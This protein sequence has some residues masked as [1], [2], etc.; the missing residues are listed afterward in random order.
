M[1]VYVEDVPIDKVSLC[2]DCAKHPELKDLVAS[3]LG[4]GI[5]GACGSTGP[6]F[7]PSRF[8]AVRN[9]IR[10][11]IRLNFDEQDY[12]SHWGGTSIDDILLGTE[13]P[14]IRTAKP[15]GL[16]DEFIYR[17][18]EEGGVYPAYDQGICLFAG[19]DNEGVRLLQFSIPQTA[20]RELKDI[21]QRLARENFHAVEAAMEKLVDSIA[22]DIESNIAE[23]TLWYR[24]RIGFSRT[25]THV[26]FDRVT[27]IVTPY[28]GA[29]ISALAP[30]RAS[31]GR[32]NRA[33]VS[34]LYVASEIE[35]ALAEIRPHPGH[36][37]SVAG[38]RPTRSFRVARFDVPIG[39]FCNSDKRLDEYAL[40]HHVDSL[41]SLPVVP[42]ERHLYATTQLLADVLIRRGFDAI[43]YRSSVGTGK[44]LCVFEP[45]LF[46][47]DETAA[48][49]RFV[50]KLD[51]QF[52]SVA[53]SR[54][55]PF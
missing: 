46:T 10:A 9:L 7:N 12:N 16:P 43:S 30:Q 25:E 14:I 31:A 34:V 33:G 15:E 19:T 29:D 27:R 3:D 18:V 26:D 20:C 38:F 39:N 2:L 22:S 42:E 40:I 55:N 4:E 6:T 53:T 17:V 51:Y 50:D 11:L 45:S 47:F 21:E 24:G 37:I 36:T 23:G 35:T 32:M 8:E 1:T 52:S 49:V 28:K 41:L 48:T 44:N 54:P 5:C 13:N